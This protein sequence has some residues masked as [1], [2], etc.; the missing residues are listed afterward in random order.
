M[1]KQ[2]KT[3]TLSQRDARRLFI[4]QQGLLRR[5][6]FGRGK[7]AVLK[8]IRQKGYVQIDTIS[9]IHRAHEHVLHSRVS[10]YQPKMLS[11]LCQSRHVYE[12]WGH[13]AAFLPFEHYRYSIPVMQGWAASRKVNKKLASQVM[14]R[15]R[16][17]GPLQSKDFEDTRRKGKSS[18]WWEWKPAK[19]ALE[20]LFLS[21]DLMVTRRDGFQKVYDLPENVIPAG[22]DTS[23]PSQGE[24]A[25]FILGS[26]SQ[27]Y[28]VATDADLAWPLATIRRLAR[29]NLAPALKQ[30]ITELTEEGTLT[31][32]RVGQL[33]C[34]VRTEL[35]DLLP[36]RLGKRELRLLSPFD[37]L[38]INR[39]RLMQLFGFDYQLECY[40][41]AAK[42]VYGYFVLPMLWGDALPGRLDAKA[43]RASKQL[44]IRNLVLE[45]RQKATAELATA[46]TSGIQALAGSNGCETTL[47]EKASPAG[48]KGELNKR[49]NA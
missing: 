43:D 10:N 34:L 47:V 37:N 28:G 7:G 49:L 15:I 23:T 38:I 24:W 17:E 31:R 3:D 22:V 19:Q 6:Q 27:A 20:H 32:V 33:D 9:V 5:D 25:R 29:V 40:V 8:S 30:A 13:A 44:L 21:G 45:P 36:L 39:R 42:R 2:M 41:P 12:Y 18:G 26:M 14:A 4:N 11:A 35:L 46:L 48:L 16:Q 1:Y